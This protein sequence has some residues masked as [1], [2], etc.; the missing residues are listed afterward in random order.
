MESAKASRRIAEVRLG[1]FQRDENGIRPADGV[2]RHSGE[3]HWN[4][5]IPFY[6]YFR[7]DDGA[8]LGASHRPAGRP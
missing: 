8:D 2:P 7:G 5:P 1:I 4:D 6:E 3:P